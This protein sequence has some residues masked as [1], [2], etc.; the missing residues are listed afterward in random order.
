MHSWPSDDMP[1]VADSSNSYSSV[2]C[3]SL[4]LI[5]DIKFPIQCST[6]I[7]YVFQYKLIVFRQFMSAAFCKRGYLSSIALQEI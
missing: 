6:V 3:L 2:D 4:Q 7:P 1:I 5:S